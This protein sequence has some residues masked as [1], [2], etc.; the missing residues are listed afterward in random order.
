MTLARDQVARTL[1]TNAGTS[2]CRCRVVLLRHDVDEDGSVGPARQAATDAGLPGGAGLVGVQDPNIMPGVLAE[3][4][5]ALALIECRS[6]A[7]AQMREVA[8]L[9]LEL[10]PTRFAAP[11]V[12]MQGVE[13]REQQRMPGLQAL[14]TGSGFRSGSDPVCAHRLATFGHM[15]YMQQSMRSP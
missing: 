1:V 7:A 4:V 10:A 8:R 11:Q 6:L 14:G 3:L 15:P 9:T 2:L 13:A 5:Q 12:A